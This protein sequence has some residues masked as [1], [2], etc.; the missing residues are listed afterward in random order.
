MKKI[1]TILATLVVLVF[2]GCGSSQPNTPKLETTKQF[3]MGSIDFNFSQKHQSEIQYHSAQELEKIFKDDLIKKL[4]EKNLLAQKGDVLNITANYTRRNVGD[5]TP[6]PS[7]ALGYPDYSYSVDFM[8]DGKSLGKISEDKLQFKGGFAMNLQVM[9]A[10]LR[11]KKYEIEFV[12]AFVNR[13]IEDIE[14][15]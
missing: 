3:Q 8:R 5:A 14:K 2:S 11:D 9:A 6:F 10:T 12:E 15:Q 4:K 7:D 1:T 13:I